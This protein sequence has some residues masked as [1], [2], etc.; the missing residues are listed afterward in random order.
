MIIHV[1]KRHITP[2]RWLAC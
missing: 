1:E 2:F